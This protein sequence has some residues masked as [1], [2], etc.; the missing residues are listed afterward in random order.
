[1]AEKGH[2]KRGN[3][4][5]HSG[6]QNSLP[7][8]PLQVQESLHGELTGISA[9]HRGTLARSQ[10]SNRPNV[11]RRRPEHAAQENSSLVQIGIH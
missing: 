8:R 7:T 3:D 2:A 9:R 11:K 6:D 10:N 4:G 5:D 1:M